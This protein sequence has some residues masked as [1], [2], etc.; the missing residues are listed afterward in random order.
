M[1]LEKVRSLS[2]ELN[3]AQDELGKARAEIRNLKLEL[4]G[5]EKE[6]FE[7]DRVSLNDLTSYLK[8]LLETH[9]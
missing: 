3:E 5:K 1:A 8:A 7:K 9:K 4:L 6:A 2:K